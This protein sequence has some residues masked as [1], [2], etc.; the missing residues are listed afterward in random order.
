MSNLAS[1]IIPKM[2]EMLK[3]V[4]PKLSRIA[5]LMNPAN[6][7]N[8]TALK[9]VQTAAQRIN[10][11]IS[12]I[13]AGTPKELEAAFAA[14]ARQ[15]PD[16]IIVIGDPFLRRQAPEIGRLALHHKLPFAA[17]NRETIAVGGLL[18]YGANISDIYW[19]GASYVDKILRGAKPA[20]LPVEQPTKIHLAI[21]RKTAKAL[22]I[23]IPQELLLRADEVIE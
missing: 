14:M 15:R 5:V 11:T 10:L 18:S 3:T 17:A 9:N 2:L 19:R 22:G 8:A 6:A 13:E 20:D 1:D 21:N 7:Q 23:T 12:P 4:L 16:A